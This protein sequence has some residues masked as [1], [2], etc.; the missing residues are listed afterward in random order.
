VDLLKHQRWIGAGVIALVAAVIAFILARETRKIGPGVTVW[1]EMHHAGPLVQ[2]SKVR[3]GSLVVGQVEEVTFLPLKRRGEVQDETTP[4]VALRLWVSRR[5]VWLLH[6]KS[7]YFVNQPSLLSEPYLEVG[8]PVK[9]DPGAPVKNG[10]IV[11]G[12]DPDT[13]DGIMNKSYALLRALGNTLHSEFPELEQ[14][15]IEIDGLVAHV[16]ELSGAPLFTGH[17]FTDLFIEVTKTKLWLGETEDELA[18]LPGTIARAKAFVARA[19]AMVVELRGKVDLL[20][21]RV[22]GLRGR[23][24]PEKLATL[25]AV[26]AQV[27]AVTRQM[28]AAIAGAD[29]LAATIARGEGTLAAFAA[30]MEIAD[31]VKA[32]TKMLKEQPWLMG[33]PLK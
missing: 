29:A 9:G 21:A 28:E 4:R 1:V 26:V 10:S 33:H 24:P 30:D 5:H 25:D 8:V 3:V 32:V 11:R 13:L 20:I 12:V 22:D 17:G 15:G 7:D 27:D 18:R 19:K 6:E 31:E 14:L 23:L 16:H 2:G